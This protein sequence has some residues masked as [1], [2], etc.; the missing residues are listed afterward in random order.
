MAD[1]DIESAFGTLFEEHR[2]L[3]AEKARYIDAGKMPPT[4]VNYELTAIVNRTVEEA[5]S[6]RAQGDA[7]AYEARALLQ[8][9]AEAGNLAAADAVA[10]LADEEPW[11]K[12][13]GD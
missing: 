2:K 1:R 8:R 7:Q 5:T 11:W 3:L 9:E 6:R 4:T 13:T 12:K 10:L